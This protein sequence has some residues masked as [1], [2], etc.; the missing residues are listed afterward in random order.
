MRVAVY[1]GIGA[2][3]ELLELLEAAG[4]ASRVHSLLYGPAVAEV[5]HRDARFSAEGDSKRASDGRLEAA[6]RCAL[7]VLPELRACT[8][9]LPGNAQ[10]G[11]RGGGALAGRLRGRRG[12]GRCVDA[13]DGQEGYK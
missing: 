8:C 10:K 2:L 9:Y 7:A 11:R 12:G 6:G 4:V 13:R 5:A 3:A 1:R